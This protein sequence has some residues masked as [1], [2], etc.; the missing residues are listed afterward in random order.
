MPVTDAQWIWFFFY[1]GG[2]LAG[3]LALILHIHNAVRRV[4]YD[5]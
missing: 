4:S 1:T 5:R 2:A 3:W